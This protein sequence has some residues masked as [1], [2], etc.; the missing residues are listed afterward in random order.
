MVANQLRNRPAKE[1][2]VI[3]YIPGVVERFRTQ[4]ANVSLRVVDQMAKVFLC[5]VRER[6]ELIDLFIQFVVLIIFRYSGCLPSLLT[7]F[8]ELFDTLFLDIYYI[9]HLAMSS[10]VVHYL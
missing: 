9:L 2:V 4:D 8:I 6:L 5:T 7:S 3:D 10:Y 1:I